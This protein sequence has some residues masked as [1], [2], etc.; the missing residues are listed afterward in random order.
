M[1]CSPLTLARMGDQAPPSRSREPTFVAAERLRRG[2]REHPELAITGL[3]LAAVVVRIISVSKGHITTAQ[4]LLRH[5][6]VT[7]LI[8]TVFGFVPYI[9]SLFIGFAFLKWLRGFVGRDS[10]QYRVSTWWLIAALYSFTL[11][12]RLGPTRD[13]ALGIVAFPIAAMVFDFFQAVR[14]HQSFDLWAERHH[15]RFTVPVTIWLWAVAVG[16]F[17]GAQLWVPPEVVETPNRTTVVYVLEDEG[18]WLTVVRESGRRLDYIRESHIVNRDV[19][20]LTDLSPPLWGFEDD[21]LAEE[22]LDQAQSR[23]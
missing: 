5:N 11:L 14:R 12:G 15:Q 17:I 19:C 8:G 3:I 7:V 21:T 2:V 1:E 23:S 18:E 9:L 10:E 13:F 16:F 22:C 6:P 20:D 4:A